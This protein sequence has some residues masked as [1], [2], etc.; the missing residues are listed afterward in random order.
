MEQQAGSW[1]CI[2]S[3]EIYFKVIQQVVQLNP[4]ESQTK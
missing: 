2:H 4:D 3:F 1:L